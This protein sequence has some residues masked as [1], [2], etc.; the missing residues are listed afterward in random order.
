MPHLSPA[1]PVSLF[2]NAVK[3]LVCSFLFSLSL[4]SLEGHGFKV[5]IPAGAIRR[6]R[7]RVTLCIQT[8]LSGDYQLPHD[9]VLVN[10]V[11]WLSLHQVM[12]RGLTRK[13]PLASSIMP[14]MMTHLLLPNAHKRHC[15]T[16][17]SHYYQEDHLLS[18]ERGLSWLSTSLHLQYILQT[19]HQYQNM[20]FAL[21]TYKEKIFLMC[22]IHITVTQ[23][24]DEKPQVCLKAPILKVFAIVILCRWLKEDVKRVQQLPLVPLTVILLL[25]HI[26]FSNSHCSFAIFS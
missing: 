10:G 9:G 8:S 26:M 1:V 25:V 14:Q 6:E 16:H 22:L 11:Y 4:L 3:Q 18:L 5:H 13:S 19:P 12:W 17:S 24:L 15:L 2:Q 7:G 23:N 20:L 21:I